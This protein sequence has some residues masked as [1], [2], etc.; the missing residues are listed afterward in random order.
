VKLL[1]KDGIVAAATPAANDADVPA[2]RKVALVTGA[3]TG[4]GRACAQ[5]L[6]ADGFRVVL[7]CNRSE[8]RAR[9]LMATLEDA[10]LVRADLASSSEIDALIAELKEKAGRIDV[11]VNNAGI[12]ADA[13]MVAM[14]LEDY[15]RVHA[16]TRGTWYLTRLVLRRF[17]YKAGRGRVINV[18]SVVGHTGNAGQTSYSMAKAALDAMTLSL[19]QEAACYGILVNSVAPGFIDTDMTSSLSGEIRGA[20]LA[21]VPLG[22]L[23][24]ADEVADVV[25]FLASRAGYMTGSVV[26]V[27]GG[28]YGG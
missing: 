17:M 16:L 15:D 4:I 18:S 7:H 19:A 11:L 1:D 21:R 27:N 24:S 5:A 28:M 3:G 26:H 6:A 12:T 8:T 10:V 14:K 20:I 2:V 9:E 25:S 13:P 23:G 22:R